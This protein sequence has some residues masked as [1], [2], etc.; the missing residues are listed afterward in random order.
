MSRIKLHEARNYL[1][2]SRDSFKDWC[3]SVGIKSY[4]YEF[5]KRQY[6]LI[7]E[8]LAKA[9]RVKIIKLKELHGENWRNYYAQHF[10]VEGFLEQKSEFELSTSNVYIPQND[11]VK[12]FYNKLKK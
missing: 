7:G 6:F 12:N 10:E 11:K 5:S 9:D 1:K 2:L 8:F 4:S 3:S